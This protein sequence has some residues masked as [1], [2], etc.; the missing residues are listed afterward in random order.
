MGALGS[1]LKL[2]E[3]SFLPP[4]IFWKSSVTVPFLGFGIRWAGPKI[5]ATLAKLGMNFGEAMTR[6]KSL[7]GLRLPFSIC[8]MVF[9]SPQIMVCWS[10][11]FGFWF[12]KIRYL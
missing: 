10:L 2:Y 9:S 8:S 5:L 7:L 1:V 6:S 12:T 4:I 11:V 3:L